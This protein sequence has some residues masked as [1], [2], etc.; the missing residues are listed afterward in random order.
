MAST[1][2]RKPPP[3]IPSTGRRSQ[4]PPATTAGR[5]SPAAPTTS[6]PAARRNTHRG[7]I[8]GGSPLS[9][10]SAVKTRAASDEAE[11]EAAAVLE[12]LRTRLAKNESAAEAAADEYNKQLKALQ[13]RLE[14]TH[15]DN[16]RLEETAH[17]KDDTI[18]S[19]EMQI[20]DLSRSRRDQENIYEAEVGGLYPLHKTQQLT[21]P[22]ENCRTARKR[23]VVGP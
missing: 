19:L 10:R 13:L 17:A 14:E 15:A 11:L 22:T 8:S 16:T 6:A 9:A 12:D 1:T 7:S 4:A 3:A 21:R 23:R 20:K 18:E 2:T 5:Q